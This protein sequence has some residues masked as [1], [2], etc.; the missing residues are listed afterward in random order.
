VPDAGA[1]SLGFSS[2]GNSTLALDIQYVHVL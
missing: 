2:L 1:E